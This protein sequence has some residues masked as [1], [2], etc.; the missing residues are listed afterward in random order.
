MNDLESVNGW[1]EYAADET[2]CFLRLLLEVLGEVGGLLD[3]SE[4]LNWP[5]PQKVNLKKVG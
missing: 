2:K 5:V 1:T 3:P 4:H